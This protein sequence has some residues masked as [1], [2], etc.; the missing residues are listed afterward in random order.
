MFLN[1]TIGKL[2]RLT[3][4]EFEGRLFML[5][6]LASQRDNRLDYFFLALIPSLAMA[7]I[8]GCWLGW[9][10][11]PRVAQPLL[12]SFGASAATAFWTIA[13]IAVET[14]EISWLALTLIGIPSCLALC[15]LF[16]RLCSLASSRATKP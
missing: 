9:R 3:Q 13:T 12:F 4:R 7:A 1:F 8:M 6:L 16:Y 14:G 2:L 11:T 15:A 5:S 10:R